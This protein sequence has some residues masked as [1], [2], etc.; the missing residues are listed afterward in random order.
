MD[1]GFH[2]VYWSCCSRIGDEIY[3]H[4]CEPTW[5]AEYWLLQ[6]Q[7]RPSNGALASLVDLTND[8][9]VQAV[10]TGTAVA[11][12]SAVQQVVANTTLQEFQ[13]VV[14]TGTAVQEVLAA[15]S[16]DTP[17]E[18]SNVAT[19][20]TGT[21]VQEVR[22]TGVV[23]QR[24]VAADSHDTPDET[25]NVAQEPPLSDD[26]I[27]LVTPD[28]TSNFATQGTDT[29]VDGIGDEVMVQENASSSSSSMRRSSRSFQQDVPAG[30]NSSRSRSRSPCPFEQIAAI[31]RA[32][33]IDEIK[34]IRRAHGFES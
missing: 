13:E 26:D 24:N 28:E 7:I 15:N 20:G 4:G 29:E 11:T 23:V 25:S 19:Q 18:T 1:Y 31:V 32:H 8:V 6:H 34:N 5:T 16:H 27:F 17:D 21:A 2:G 10:A 22:A 14:A 3:I 30:Q 33:A 12:G 9:D